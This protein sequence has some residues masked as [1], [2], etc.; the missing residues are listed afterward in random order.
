MTLRDTSYS[1][2][3]IGFTMLEIIIA[4]SIFAIVITMLFSS[5]DIVLSNAS[6]IKERT[7]DVEMIKNCIDRMVSDLRSIHLHLR[8][9][10]QPPG[11][12]ADPEPYRVVGDA[13]DIGPKRFS[14]LRFTSSAHLPFTHNPSPDGIAEIVYYVQETDQ[15]TFVIRRAD[16]LY[17]YSEFEEDEN[18]PLLCDSIQSLAFTYHDEDGEVHESWDSESPDYKYATPNALGIAMEVGDDASTRPY[19]TTV[20]LPVHRRGTG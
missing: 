11:L 9:S 12:D 15:D 8:P 17:P 18:D 19:G 13:T 7:D 3:Q 20:Y 6:S 16:S 14:R 5:H 10:Y 4:I 2:N 1:G